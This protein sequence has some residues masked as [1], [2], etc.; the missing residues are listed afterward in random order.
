[1]PSSPLV[2]LLNHERV[3][4]EIAELAKLHISGLLGVEFDQVAV[5]W[6]LAAGGKVT[7]TFSV[8]LPSDAGAIEKQYVQKGIAEVWLGWAKR[9]LIDRLRGLGEVRRYGDSKANSGADSR[10]ALEPEKEA[11]GEKVSEGS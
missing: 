9:E 11:P 8:Q 4:G 1:M 5:E 10:E 2:F 6:E 7:S 3:L